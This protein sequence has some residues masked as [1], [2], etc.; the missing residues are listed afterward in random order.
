[1]VRDRMPDLL[2]LTLS[3]LIVQMVH[4]RDLIENLARKRTKNV[5]DFEWICQMRYYFNAEDQS[6]DVKMIT[7]S[8]KYCNEFLKN[9][10]RLVIT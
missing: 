6:I 7:T 10:G 3:S 1:M 9:E 8:L 5:N 2:R 4:A